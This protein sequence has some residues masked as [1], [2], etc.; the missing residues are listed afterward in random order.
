MSSELV[1]ISFTLLDDALLLIL[2]VGGKLSVSCSAVGGVDGIC[3]GSVCGAGI[4]RS[5]ILASFLVCWFPWN[6][7]FF[8]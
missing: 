3:G 1:S 8:L 5:L 7:R 4:V 6:L 2:Y